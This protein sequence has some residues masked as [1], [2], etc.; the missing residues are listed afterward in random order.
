M[1]CVCVYPKFLELGSYSSSTNSGKS[2]SPSLQLDRMMAP[3]STNSNSAPPLKVSL[4]ESRKSLLA[5]S[6]EQINLNHINNFSAISVS[7][8]KH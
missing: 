5:A 7:Y 1:A 4:N 6:N 3:E 8:L 2:G